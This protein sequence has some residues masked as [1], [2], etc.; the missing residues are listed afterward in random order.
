MFITYIAYG[1]QKNIIQF[2]DKIRP[3]IASLNNLEFFRYESGEEV[4]EDEN[5]IYA[6]KFI[7]HG[8]SNTKEMAEIAEKDIA[9]LYSFKLPNCSYENISFKAKGVSNY[10]K[11]KENPYA[12]YTRTVISKE[13]LFNTEH[14]LYE[15]NDYEDMEFYEKRINE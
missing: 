11:L 9:L 12:N 8:K 1:E 2:L 13:E 6:I 7:Y 4:T 3:Y 15:L 5:L 10:S 14:V